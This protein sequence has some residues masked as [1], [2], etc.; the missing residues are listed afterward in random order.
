[1]HRSRSKHRVN[2]SRKIYK[3]DRELTYPFVPILPPPV[4]NVA[5]F[6]LPVGVNLGYTNLAGQGGRGFTLGGELSLV[7]VFPDGVDLPVAFGAATR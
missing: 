7:R 5:D 6:F 2:T 4:S 3:P 1:M